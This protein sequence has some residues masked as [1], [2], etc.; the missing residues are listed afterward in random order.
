MLALFISGLI[1]LAFQDYDTQEMCVSVLIYTVII[2]AAC[3]VLTYINGSDGLAL[4]RMPA[5]LKECLIGAVSVSGV[6]L[7]F[8]FVLTP[9]YYTLF[10]SQ[11]HKDIRRLK[12]ALK[13]ETDERKRKKLTAD[14]ERSKAR[15]KETGPVFGFGMGD[16]VVMAAG[17]LM[18]GWKAAVTAGITAVILGAVY[19]L[20]RGATASDDD[21]NANRFAFGPF[22]I[23]GLVLGAYFGNNIIDAYLNYMML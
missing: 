3:H 4:V 7:I 19:G 2:A 21:E 1:V 5:D 16:V 10:L 9:I 13:T 15:I 8:G 23:I 20:Y 17:G 11:D 6:I 22:L 14:I 18:L 12:R